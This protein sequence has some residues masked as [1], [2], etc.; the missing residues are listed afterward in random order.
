MVNSKPD[1]IQ[2]Y[3]LRRDRKHVAHVQH[4]TLHTDRFGVV[5][6]HGLFGSDEWWQAISSGA[7]ETH[8]IEGRISRVY[9]TGAPGGN[10][11]EFEVDDGSSRTQWAR[12]GDDDW[13]VV[14]RRI[15]VDFVQTRLRYD[16]DRV[17]SVLRIWIGDDHD[18]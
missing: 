2:V 14:G 18:A 9:M 1:M 3:D 10:F 5:P 4:A 16:G 7:I 13:Y 15:R 8:T 11:P 12:L 6:D 17:P